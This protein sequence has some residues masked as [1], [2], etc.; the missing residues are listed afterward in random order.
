[1]K[2]TNKRT[3]WQDIEMGRILL[4]FRAF[5]AALFNRE[6]S[7]RILKALEVQPI[8]ETTP[9]EPLSAPVKREEPAPRQNPALT[10]LATLQREGRLVDFLNEDLTGY[11]DDQVGAA[12]REIHRDCAAAVRR[13]FAIQPIVQESEGK[14]IDVPAGFDA[15]RFRLTGK[16][17]GSGPYRGQ[18]RHHGWEATRC[19]L[20]AYTGSAEACTTLAAAEIEVS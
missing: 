20:P 13:I 18:L 5:F 12:V 14:P 1:L 11:S 8:T 4:A 3:I 16:V 2:K 6:L 19:D 10:L 9:A 17:T 15:A 7:S